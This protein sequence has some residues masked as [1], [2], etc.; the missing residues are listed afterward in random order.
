MWCES[1]SSPYIGITADNL[2][3]LS[4]NVEGLIAEMLSNNPSPFDSL[5]PGVH[6]GVQAKAAVSH[7]PAPPNRSKPVM[8]NAD[9]RPRMP[10]TT[11]IIHQS[12]FKPKPQIPQ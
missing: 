7:R 9:Q 6:P 3:S 11:T 10:G 2:A 1:Y 4:N 12:G 8:P 5:T